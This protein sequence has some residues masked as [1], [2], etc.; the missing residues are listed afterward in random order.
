MPITGTALGIRVTRPIVNALLEYDITM[1][2]S[3]VDTIC[4]MSD[5]TPQS[6]PVFS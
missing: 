6:G 5:C 1:Q 3:A 2:L 4:H